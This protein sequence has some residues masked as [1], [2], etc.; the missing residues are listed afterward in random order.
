MYQ[1]IICIASTPGKCTTRATEVCGAY[2]V[3]EPLHPMPDD[4]ER[5]TM[6]VE[7]HPEQVYGGVG[8]AGP[9]PPN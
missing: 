1:R 4:P 8:D 9:V 7:C 2:V 5:S 3:K 6:A